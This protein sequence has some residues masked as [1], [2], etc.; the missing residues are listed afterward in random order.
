MS[1][2]ELRTFIRQLSASDPDDRDVQTI[3]LARLTELRDYAE[4]KNA[5]DVV[6]LMDSARHL[7][8]ALA[9]PSERLGRELLGKITCRVLFAVTETLESSGA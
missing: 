1:F 3:N 8:A 6:S 5:A 7:L 4:S 2:P 9:G